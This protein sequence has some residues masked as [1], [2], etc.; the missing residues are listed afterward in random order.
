MVL[1]HP[2]QLPMGPATVSGVGM[3]GMHAAVTLV[4]PPS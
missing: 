2:G 3:L 1:L 4:L